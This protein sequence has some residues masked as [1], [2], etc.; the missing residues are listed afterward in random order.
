M[1]GHS[2]KALTNGV[3]P[4]EA[5]FRFFPQAA[6]T[7]PMTSAAET[8]HDPGGVV[9]NVTQT[10]AGIFLVKMRDPAHRVIMVNPVVQLAANNVDLHGQAGAISYESDGAEFYVKTMA[11][12]TPT[13]IAAGENN[14]V[15][16]HVHIE[17]S[18]AAGVP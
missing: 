18:S 10:A 2:K 11:G 8:L 4:R 7:T 6:S 9:D 13:A 17:D 12:T 1:R 14:S 3:R 16:V 15:M 5:F